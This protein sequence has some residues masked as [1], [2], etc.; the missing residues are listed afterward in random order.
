MDLKIHAAQY[1]NNDVIMSVMAS[2]IT[3]L[4][5]VYSTVRSKKTSK[6]R[7]TGLCPGN[8]PVTGEWIP[9]A[10]GRLRGK[11]SIWWRHHGMYQHELNRFYDKTM[12]TPVFLSILHKGWGQWNICI[13]VVYFTYIRFMYLRWRQFEVVLLCQCDCCCICMGKY[14]SSNLTLPHVFLPIGSATFQRQLRCYLTQ[15]L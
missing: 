9:R 2:Q 12:V 5:I 7:V 3:S 11:V 4:T 8:S 1:H 6:L 10:N 13:N 15:D 14:Y